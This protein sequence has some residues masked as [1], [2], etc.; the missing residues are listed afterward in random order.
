M[1]FVMRI[2]VEV[3]HTNNALSH[4]E[5]VTI[6]SSR[7]L[8]YQDLP[9]SPNMEA[10]QETIQRAEKGYCAACHPLDLMCQK[11]ALTENRVY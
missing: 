3:S 5:H 11:T 4:G 2:A 10:W 6:I 7:K 8:S 9:A 1:A